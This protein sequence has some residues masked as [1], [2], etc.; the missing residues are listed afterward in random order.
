[1][2]SVLFPAAAARSFGARKFKFCCTGGKYTQEGGLKP[3]RALQRPQSRAPVSSVTARAHGHSQT[4]VTASSLGALSK[5]SPL[6]SFN[7]IIH[8]T[9]QNS[10]VFRVKHPPRCIKQQGKAGTDETQSSCCSPLAE[11]VGCHAGSYGEQ[12]SFCP[13]P[14]HSHSSSPLHIHPKDQD[15]HIQHQNL[16]NTFWISALI[17]SPHKFSHLT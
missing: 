1:M 10:E 4:W 15:C 13:T 16:Q 3:L 8:K 9:K 6:P 5:N 17:G 12:S 14:Q 2:N 11:G 7:C